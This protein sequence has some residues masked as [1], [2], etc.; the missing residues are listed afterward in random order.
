MS[1]NAVL[2]LLIQLSVCFVRGKVGQNQGF[3]GILRQ[4]DL[5]SVSAQIEIR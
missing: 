5:R 1:T 2:Q 4:S 3:I